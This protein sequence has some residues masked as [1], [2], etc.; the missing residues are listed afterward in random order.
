MILSLKIGICHPQFVFKFI[1][2]NFMTN[3]GGHFEIDLVAIVTRFFSGK[4]YPFRHLH[5]IWHRKPLVEKFFAHFYNPIKTWK[6]L[7]FLFLVSSHFQTAK[8][9]FYTVVK[10]FN[11]SIRVGCFLSE[12]IDQ[13]SY[14]GFSA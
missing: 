1:F 6:V 13:L 4:N 8:I 3:Y 7:T 9:S 10:I 11:H 2:F 12:K 5:N 14:W